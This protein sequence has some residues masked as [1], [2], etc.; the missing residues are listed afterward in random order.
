LKRI[1]SRL[2]YA[3]VMSSI[4]VFLVLGG[5]TAFAASHLGKNSVG[6]KQLKA[7]SVTSSKIKK[8]AI[9]T[10]KIKNG[11]VTGA[12]IK[13]A[14]APFSQATARLRVPGPIAFGST[15][16]VSIGTYAQP[17]G[18][19]DQFIAG[20]EVSFN[21]AC[22][23]PREAVA[24][25]SINPVKPNELSMGDISAIG[26]V[27]DETGASLT[28]K[29]NFIAY[30]GLGFKPLTSFAGPATENQTFYM[31]PLEIECTS[32]TETGTAANLGVDVIGTK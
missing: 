14:S 6:S 11:A 23:A 22:V 19:D 15:A 17:A 3:N 2:T 4:A 26:I 24:Y 13:A 10:A 16:P 25:F 28:H 7:N 20:M 21:P 18:E 29:M 5:A 8:N 30:P 9:T 1:R 27:L 12:K 31:Y 32:G